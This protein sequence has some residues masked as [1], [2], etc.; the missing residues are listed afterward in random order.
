MKEVLYLVLLTKN[1]NPGKYSYYGFSY[2]IWFDARG[3]FSL[4][5]SSGVSK[6]V[7]IFQNVERKI[8]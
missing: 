3:T 6:N 1:A 2:G 4:S 7:I 5:D 8:S